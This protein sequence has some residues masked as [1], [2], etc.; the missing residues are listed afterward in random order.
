MSVVFRFGPMLTNMLALAMT[1]LLVACGTSPRSTETGPGQVLVERSAGMTT[2]ATTESLQAQA[3]AQ[4]QEQAQAARTAAAARAVQRQQSAVAAAQPVAASS[5]ASVAVATSV[6][7]VT[8]PAQTDTPTQRVVYFDF[9]R[10][11][12]RQEFQPMIERRA[13]ALLAQSGGRLVLEGHA[14][15]R[16][17]REYNLSLGQRRAQAVQRALVL[18][19]VPEAQLAA[20]S[21]GD[22]RPAVEGSSEVAWS[23]NRRVE[24]KAP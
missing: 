23:Q 19:G 9:D 14:D 21:L 8:A 20:I 2:W 4:A 5:A 15:E 1:S 6:P 22:T 10:D 7:P 24:L 13:R 18:L 17:S 16:G 3:Q 12:I 11:D